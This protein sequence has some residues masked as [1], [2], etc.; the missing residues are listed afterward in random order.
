MASK[1]EPSN[2]WSVTIQI[3]SELE[4]CVSER[5]LNDEIRRLP[6]GVKLVVRTAQEVNRDSK[7]GIRFYP[8]GGASGG[9]LDL[10][11][12]GADGVRVSVDWLMGG[13]SHA[14]F[15]LD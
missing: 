12:A 13:I 6:S 7:G 1:G 15:A 9:D 2:V 4:Q 3:E 10:E 11:R 5:N 8:E 14:R